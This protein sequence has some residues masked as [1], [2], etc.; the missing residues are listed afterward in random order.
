MDAT[1]F[2]RLLRN[3]L[4]RAILYVRDHDVREFRDIIL[5][6]CLHSPAY[7]VQLEGSRAAY[8][9]ELVALLPDR[10]FF[11]SEVVR[12]LAHGGDD[13][14]AFYR[15]EFAAHLASERDDVKRTMYEAFGPGP[16]YG[17]MAGVLLLQ[18]D[19]M[20][21]FLFAAARIGARHD[22]YLLSQACQA[23]GEDATWTALQEAAVSN[24]DIE[25]FRAVAWERRLRDHERQPR[26]NPSVATLR[27]PEILEEEKSPTRLMK[28]AEQASDEEI[29]LAAEGLRLAATGDPARLLAHLRIFR[30]RRYP[31]PDIAPLLLKLAES[32]DSQIAIA[33]LSALGNVTDPAVRSLALRMMDTGSELRGHAADLLASNFEPGDHDLVLLWFVSEQDADVRHDLGFDLP[34]FWDRHPDEATRIRML[35]ALYEYGPCS[36]CREGAVRRLLE[37]KALPDAV[38]EECAWDSSEEIREL[39]GGG[40]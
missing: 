34:A 24:P 30:E 22:G 12:A 21:G 39:L 37:S 10:D 33:A 32:D 20:P 6:A 31:R 27:Y 15:L 4:G 38:R 29:E 26:R 19:G 40:S 14:D 9:H 23:L 17:E 36:L 13:Q 35:L 25:A 7:D 8:M 18:L 28:W 5:N 1:E 16:N 3:G 2:Q 11:Q